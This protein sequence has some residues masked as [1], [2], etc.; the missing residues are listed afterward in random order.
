MTAFDRFDRVGQKTYNGQDILKNHILKR[1]PI[2][3]TTDV[4]DYTQA[5]QYADEHDFVWLVEK[6]FEVLRSFPWFFIPAK[7]DRNS[8]HLF[9]YIYKAS[10][11][12]KSW[13]KVQ[14]VPT[15]N[16]TNKK[17]TQNHI[18]NVYD[19][20]NGKDRFDIFYQGKDT[21]EQYVK[22]KEKFN[23]IGVVENYW[24]A[25][26]SSETEMFW[27]IPDDVEVSSIFKFNYQPDD[28]S[29]KFTHVFV[30]GEEFR[31]GIALFPKQYN[32]TD[33]ELKYRYYTNKKELNIVASVP[34]KYPI[35]NFKDYD[36]YKS[37]L[38]TT[39]SDLFWYVPDDVEVADDFD[40]GFYFEHRNQ[41][42][43]T[44][45]H[46]F[47]NN[48]NYDGIVLFSRFNPV[49]DKEFNHRFYTNKKE[50]EVV[51][52][53]P[54][55]FDQFVVNNYADYKL[56]LERSTTE[57]FYGIPDDVQVDSRFDFDIY[58]SHHNQYDRNITHVF[59][60]NKTYD[61]IVLFSK[62]VELAE[63]EVNNR[64]YIK[65]K[66][67]DLIASNPRTYD[68]FEI[69]NYNDYLHALENTTTNLFWASSRNIKITDLEKLENF[70]ISHHEVVDRNQN[71]VFLHYAN[72]AAH[73]NG[74]MLLCKNKKLSEKEIVYRF[75][76]ERKEWNIV[77]SGP[78]EYDQFVV[79]TYDDYLQAMENSTT[80]LFWAT[81]NNI[82][83]TIPN[84]YF[85][86]DNE[87]DRKINHAFEHR[88]DG[89]VMYNGLFLLSKYKPITQKEI[90]YR[91]I[92]DVK[93]W[94]VYGSQRTTYDIF[95]IETYE[96]YLL[97]LE[98]SKTEMFWMTS[99]NIDT[100]DFGFDLYFSHDN[101]YDRKRNH[102]FIHRVGDKDY[103]NGVFLLSK[104]APVT[105]KEIKHRFIVNAKE[106]DIVASGPEQYDMFTVENWDDYVDAMKN[107]STEL[108][109][110]ISNNIDT[111]D[112]D[113][114]SVYFT[115]DNEFDR[116]T[117][118]CFAHLVNGEK[119]YNGLMLLSKHN[120]LTPKEIEHRFP[121]DRKEWDTVASKPVK[122]DFYYIETYSDYLN[123]LDDFGTEL[124]WAAS[125]NIKVDEEILNKI[126]FTH[127]NEYDRKTNHS[128]IHRVNSKDYRNGL[129]L[130]SKHSTVSQKEIEHRFIVNAKEWD[131]VGSEPVQYPVFEIDCYNDY[132][133]ALESTETELFWMS[134]K[135]ITATIPDL[136]FTHD[137]EYDRTQNHNFIHRVNGKDYRNGLFLCS[138]HKPLTQK[139][140]EHRF[141]VDAKEWDIVGSSPRFYDVFNI[142]SYD[143]Y[144]S[145][146]ENSKTEMFWMSSANISADIPDLYFT[147]DNEYDRKRN[148][149]FLHYNGKR[150]GVF[151]CSTYKP[152]T[153][154]EV[155]HRF[156]VDAKEW[157]IVAS[158]PVAYDRF[159]INN[160]NDYL[161]ALEQSKT[162]MFWG[163]PGDV[164]V[165]YD[166]DLYF[167]HDNEYDRKTNHVM[168][169]GEHRDG[170]VLFSKHAPVT[171]RELENRFYM[172]KKDWNIIASI[173][174]RYDFFDIE[175]YDEYLDALEKSST[176]MFWASTPNIKIHKDFDLDLYF[177]HH[178]AYDRKIN[179][180]FVHRANGQ[181]Y[182]NGLFLLSKH[183]P[184]TQR[185]I[186][187]RLVAKR[188]EWDI[189]ASGPVQYD[190]FVVDTYKDYENALQKSTT[191]MFWM[192]PPEVNVDFDFDLYFT[193][194][195]WFERET[196]HVFKN[197][198]AWDGISLVSKKSHITERE[199]NM[200]FLANKKQY[201]VVASTPNLY[202]IVFISKD[203]EHADANYAKLSERFPRAKRVH[204][205]EGIHA[206]HIE[207]AKL[208]DT[209]MI[210]IVDADAE[211]ID[212]FAF[213]YYV[214]AYDPDSRKTVHV[215]KSQNPINGLVYGYGAV[216]LLPRELTLN[217]DTSKPDMTTSI[218]PLFKTINRISNITRFN[219][220]EFS[221]WRSAFRE[222]VKLSS[223]TINGQLDEE[224]EF[225]L[226]AWCTR[227]KD[228]PF[229]T[230]AISGANLGKEYGEKHRDSTQDLR[231]I[232]DFNWLRE[233]FNQIKN[234]L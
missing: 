207:A 45:N 228:K 153:E 223:K 150:N 81:S 179:H 80:E 185:E 137:N 33:K 187:H 211:I 88:V 73:K 164:I 218:S 142:D 75:P 184:L 121:I 219:T 16:R 98:N 146:L 234:S 54:K 63:R 148:H 232:N 116:K 96:D 59:L 130:L 113:F 55:K 57:M 9:P 209:D 194:N 210:W 24:Q 123:A 82:D 193:H 196:N 35:Y 215:W 222:C 225:R 92:I 112:F 111:D 144:L 110:V 105:E 230:A 34:K 20:Y 26:E 190:R 28:W 125:R 169:N 221:T 56:A 160:Y 198:D 10:K 5:D 129:F 191:E 139:E 89:K 95:D 21:D 39:D 195:Q 37:V 135:N 138:T 133:T 162:E 157:D 151:L 174:K 53:R 217:M 30:N 165:D 134:S 31:D 186:E 149:N 192:I 114:S 136:Y 29:H 199:I 83:Y 7:D 27:F 197:G 124:F 171:Q 182:Y 71:H 61:G 58:F 4:E 8:V 19:F 100:V 11:R 181:D 77:L 93:E 65:K 126:Y 147:H 64:F 158:K 32:P 99:P 156:V 152:L 36:E 206:A 49:T 2:H 85:T 229:G 163:I 115:H 227:G 161:F 44:T 101:E 127:D 40:F 86:H 214:P 128:F 47:L 66:E 108:F 84:L 173:P 3:Y 68:I 208:C 1:H 172:N 168:L 220:D 72:E 23:N 175:T 166:F 213:D 141:V 119:Y 15:K 200:R 18:V 106:W 25:Q 70:Y 51:A 180:T 69:D 118:H 178:N 74:L 202:D 167:T 226:N 67:W 143:E 205:V 189:V 104:H 216:K 154:R 224:T 117:N 231:R 76:L 201:D 50:W 204:G 97:A 43:R 188:K 22:L 103:R 91:H 170:I 62:N 38:D 122:Y 203:E 159:E 90:E 183:A 109:W 145:A 6:D 176:D 132:L 212:K 14:L 13:K 120:Q 107:S 60:N 177:S 17:V 79:E 41:Y 42:D 52:S 48:K 155:E 12:V 87:Y 78:V 94:P 233:Q 46:V 140:V 102:N 131:I